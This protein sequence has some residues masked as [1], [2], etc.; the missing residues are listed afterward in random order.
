[1]TPGM[2]TAEMEPTTELTSEN[3][4]NTT[5]NIKRLDNSHGRFFCRY[6]FKHAQVTPNDPAMPCCRFN[7]HFLDDKDK[8]SITDFANMFSDI[9]KKMINNEYVPGCWK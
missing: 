1:M 5:R 2:I 9:R 8:G 7:H 3:I 6:P 4:S